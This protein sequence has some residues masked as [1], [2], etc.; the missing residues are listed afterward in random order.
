MRNGYFLGVLNS[1]EAHWID[2]TGKPE[3]ELA[4]ENCRKA[5][6]VEDAGFHRLAITF[7]EIA[8]DYAREAERVIDRHGDESEE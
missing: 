1:R 3:R 8:S 5:N 7:R 6:E 4:E 2:P